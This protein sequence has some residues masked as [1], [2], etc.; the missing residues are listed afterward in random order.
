M[1]DP[2]GTTRVAVVHP[3][4]DWI[5]RVR[6]ALDRWEAADPGTPT[7]SVLGGGAI[8]AAEEEF[9]R[10]LGGRPVLLM[11]SA[12]YALRVGLQVIGVQPGDEVLC[13]AID[14][15]SG[16]AAIA[17]LGAIP[18]CVAMDPAT[19]TVDPIAAAKARTG[20]TRAVIACHLHGIC[21][22][23]PALRSLLPGVGI[24]EDAA[25]A[26]GSRLDGL[27]AGSLGDVAV[28]SLG[29]GK[30]ID[31]AEGGV[32]VCGS[33]RTYRT[34]VGLACHPLRQLLAGIADADPQALAMRPHPM[35]AVLALDALARWSPEPARRAHA[36]ARQLL[37]ADGRLRPLGHESRHA[38]TH[39]H[40]PVLLPDDHDHPEAGPLEP[41]PGLWWTRSGAQV[42]PGVRAEDQEAAAGLLARVRIAAQRNP[43]P[44]D[45]DDHDPST[46]NR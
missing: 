16:L 17:S 18:V 39:G 23:I 34:A 21:A 9:R 46:G 28:L 30:P 41:P 22:D 4:R 15:P 6:G 27:P 38:I 14:W 42:L 1:A 3:D 40:V 45:A 44:P 31:A 25:Q 19:L 26:F 2:L 29:P 11:P 10:L 13:G 37:A 20:R 5:G 24:L 35:T 33:T 36:R 8:A 7:S 32:L 12:T 43:V